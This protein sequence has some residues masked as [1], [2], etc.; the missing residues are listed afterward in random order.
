M[1]VVGLSRKALPGRGRSQGTCFEFE[2]LSWS[3]FILVG[4]LFPGCCMV[5]ISGTLSHPFLLYQHQS[6]GAGCPWPVC[7]GLSQDR[8]S[9]FKLLLLGHRTED[10]ALE[11][12]AGHGVVSHSFKAPCWKKKKKHAKLSTDGRRCRLQGKYIAIVGSSTYKILF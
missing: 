12:T 8:P 3:W 2:G 7:S 1:G 6:H 10:C 9:L 5:S 11:S 4:S